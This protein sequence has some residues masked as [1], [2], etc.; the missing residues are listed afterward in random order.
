MKKKKRKED[1]EVEIVG[2][3]NEEQTRLQHDTCNG[4]LENET[5]VKKKKKKK[6][7]EG[8]DGLANDAE[9]AVIGSTD[10]VNMDKECDV[11]GSSDVNSHKKKKKKKKSVDAT[12]SIDNDI[13]DMDTKESIDQTGNGIIKENNVNADNLEWNEQEGEKQFKDKDEDEVLED[14]QPSEEKVQGERCF[15]ILGKHAKPKSATVKRLLPRWL[16]EPVFIPADINSSKVKVEDVSYLS[17]NTVKNLQCWKFAH[18]FPVQSYVV[19]EVLKQNKALL[20][21]F[22]PRDICVQVGTIMVL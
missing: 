6:K 22:P 7:K 13:N 15:P 10:N 4:D 3:A 12:D 5:P 19:E 8:E 16:N 9:D 1:G 21:R 17:A 11:E 20:N 18:L 14:D 2:G